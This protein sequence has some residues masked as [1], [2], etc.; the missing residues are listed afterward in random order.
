MLALWPDCF[1]DEALENC[2][3]ILAG[4]NETCYL[5]R[6]D[7]GYIAFVHLTLRS[8]YVEGADSLPVA[9][10]E[11]IYVKESHRHSGVAKKLIQTSE[12]WARQKGCKQLASDTEVHNIAGIK[13]HHKNGFQEANRLVCF[14]KEL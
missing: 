5:A 6:D 2:R 4:K 14:I 13:F 3:S 8:D 7:E 12:A 1:F 10:L 11:G 9:Y